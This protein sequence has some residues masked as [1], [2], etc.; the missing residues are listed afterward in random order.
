MARRQ[1]KPQS[2]PAEP[3]YKEVTFIDREFESGDGAKPVTVTLTAANC[4][5]LMAILKGGTQLWD[6]PDDKQI[7]KLTADFERQVSDAIRPR[8]LA[9]KTWLRAYSRG[10]ADGL[11]KAQ[12]KT[13]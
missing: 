8:L 9:E 6:E 3:T 12:N 4:Y 2:L 13:V 5:H 7:T 1:K 10:H 11:A